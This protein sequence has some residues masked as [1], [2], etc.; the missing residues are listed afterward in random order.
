MSDHIWKPVKVEDLGWDTRV[1][2]EN[3]LG[4]EHIH[5]ADTADLYS[6]GRSLHVLCWS[7]CSGDW[8]GCR[9][10]CVFMEACL[11]YAAAEHRELEFVPPVDPFKIMLNHTRYIDEHNCYVEEFDTPKGTHWEIAVD[12][13]QPLLEEL[14]KEIQP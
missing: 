13:D 5:L 10:G 1:I 12:I 6:D 14:D 9:K 8:P 7:G 2:Y 4:E 11:E 3:E